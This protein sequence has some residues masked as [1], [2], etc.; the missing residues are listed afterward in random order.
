MNVNER[1]VS[2]ALFA[3]LIALLGGLT[4]MLVDWPERSIV[5]A[6]TNHYDG[7]FVSDEA[8]DNEGISHSSTV[9]YYKDTDPHF[10][11]QAYRIHYGGR[12]P[13]MFCAWNKV[14]RMDRRK[15]YEWDVGDREW[16]LVESVGASDYR[17]TGTPGIAWHDDYD[18]VFM[19][20]GAY[21]KQ[22]LR[23]RLTACNFDIPEPTDWPG[24]WHPHFLE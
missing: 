22:R 2:L 7:P 12:R 14:W 8:E 5:A 3:V 4:W 11:A 23:Y 9:W 20:H 24:R 18:N 21:V 17:H 1:R 13:E 6:S 10:V 16:T 19:D 15:Y